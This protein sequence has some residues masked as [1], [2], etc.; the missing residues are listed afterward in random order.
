[1]VPI[2]FICMFMIQ[3]D[4]QAMT[5]ATSRAGSAS[6]NAALRKELVQADRLLDQ[7]DGSFTRYRVAIGW[8]HLGEENLY[9]EYCETLNSDFDYAYQPGVA[10][11]I[12]KVCMLRPDL[13]QPEN[14]ERAWEL[15]EFASGFES[16]V[17]IKWFQSTRALAEL[18]RGNLESAHEWNQK[19][20]E[21]EENTGNGYRYAMSQ[22]VDSLAWIGLGDIDKAK[23]ALEIGREIHQR[24]KEKRLRT[25]MTQVGKTGLCFRFLKKKFSRILNRRPS[26]FL[27]PCPASL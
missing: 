26:I 3:F 12:A 9:R 18:R 24:G 16:S 13:Q 25:A 15:T 20:R 4:F 21:G 7:I 22:A 5:G 6:D 1:M 10:S 2:P 19:C 23:Q 14:L 11:R 8:L 17:D 27:C